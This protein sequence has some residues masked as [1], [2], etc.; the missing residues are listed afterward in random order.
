MYPTTPNGAGYAFFGVR[1]FQAFLGIGI[2]NPSGN[3]NISDGSGRRNNNIRRWVIS[4]C[5]KSFGRGIVEVAIAKTLPGVLG[6]LSFSRP[7]HKANVDK[8]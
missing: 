5:K 4:R 2:D 8:R 7:H 6:R 1:G 3:Y